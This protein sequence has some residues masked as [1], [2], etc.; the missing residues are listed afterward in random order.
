MEAKGNGKK[1]VRMILFG[2]E[3]V[4]ILAMLAV[5]YLVLNQSSDGPRMVELNPEVL[6]IHEEVRQLKE[7]G[8]TMLGYRNIA[9]FGLDAETDN[10]LYK[11]SHSDSIMIASINLDTGDIRLVSVYRDTYLNLGAEEDDEHWKYWKATQAYFY[12]GAEQAVK[13]LN[14]NLDMDI[15]DFVAVGYKGLRGVIDGLGGIYLDVDEEERKHLNNYQIGVSSVLKCGYTPVEEAGYQLLNGLQ[16]TAYCRIRATAGDDFKRTARQREV[17]KAIEAQ[18]KKMDLVTLTKVFNDCI[19]DIYTSL[20]SGD[21]LELLADIGKY[22]IVEEGGFPH[23]DLRTTGN[24]GA[25][26][27]CVIPLDLEANV[28]WLHQFL[29]GDED[30]SVTESVVE[31]GRQIEEDTSPY[32]QR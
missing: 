2:L 28:V 11:S 15:T 32:L 30:Y 22:S 9:L 10:Q 4:I 18:A 3:V 27:S 1:K 13:M 6:E 16:A 29:F 17:L 7:E 5:L 19:G 21:I 20:D 25:K 12:G 26:K 8:G 14:M 23:E 31:Y 24:L